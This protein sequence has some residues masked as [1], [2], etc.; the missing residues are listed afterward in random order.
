MDAAHYE[1]R[2]L[3]SWMRAEPDCLA[4]YV[5]PLGHAELRSELPAAHHCNPRVPRLPLGTNEL[6]PFRGSLPQHL[7]VQVQ[8]QMQMYDPKMANPIEPT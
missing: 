3:R 7:Q 2:L 4:R 8:M 6:E 5:A 1:C